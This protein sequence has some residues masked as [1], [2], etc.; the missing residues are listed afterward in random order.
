MIN[1][2]SFNSYLCWS[3]QKVFLLFLSI[4]WF[5]QVSY[6]AQVKTGISTEFASFPLVRIRERS[7]MF[8]SYGDCH[9]IILHFVRNA[10]DF[11]SSL[12][13]YLGLRALSNERQLYL[14]A[15]PCVNRLYNYG[16]NVSLFII[17]LHG[18]CLAQLLCHMWCVCIIRQFR[19]LC[20]THCNYKHIESFHSYQIVFVTV[21]I[22]NGFFIH[23]LF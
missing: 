8:K 7:A 2:R 12:C 1:I 14:T 10:I 23:S 16:W 9:L 22:F 17:S 19:A 5:Q 4:V 20:K 18:V 21:R 11:M 13:Q 15:A 3:F 6:L